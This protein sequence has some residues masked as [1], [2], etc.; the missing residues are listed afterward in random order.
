MHQLQKVV[1]LELLILLKFA[2]KKVG[3]MRTT[4]YWLIHN[5]RIAKEN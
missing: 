3:A 2:D 5:P 1:S 4:N